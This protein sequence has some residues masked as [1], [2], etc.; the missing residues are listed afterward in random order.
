MQPSG[1]NRL[2]S[3]LSAQSRQAMLSASTLRELPV[4]TYLYYP[5]QELTYVYL[6]TS[7]IA[8]VV[9]P[10]MNGQTAEVSLIGKEGLTG[11]LHLLGHADSPMSC[12]VQLSATGLR[13]RRTDME[14]LFH[15]S[16]EIRHRT[17]EFVQQESFTLSQ[18]AGCNSLHTAGPR[19][20]RWLLMAQDR[21]DSPILNFTQEFL[22]EM[23]G[24]QRTTVNAVAN[25]L[26]D[27]G[28]I[29]YQRGRITI[30]DRRG[31]EQHACSCYQAARDR[32]IALYQ[33][34]WA[35]RSLRQSTDRRS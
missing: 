7:G 16:E 14:E 35:P 21:T 27:A 9:L 17:L 31:M 6:L 18:I 1:E 3:S 15:C 13:I 2:L 4:G 34:P 26:Q 8:S 30:T 22:A 11:A 29:E 20:A 10:M 28:L 33:K 12:F 32:Y 23:L 5:G 24:L 25:R 19:L